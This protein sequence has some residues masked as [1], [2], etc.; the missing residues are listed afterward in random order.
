MSFALNLANIED[1]VQKPQEYGRFMQHC[2]LLF[3]VRRLS[4]FS[5]AIEKTKASG[6]AVDVGSGNGILSL[7]A[8]KHGYEHVFMIEPSDKI[9]QYAT[10]LLEKNGMAGRFTIIDQP[11][12]YVNLSRLPKQLGLVVS[13]T[14]SSLIFGFGSWD[15]FPTLVSRV[16]SKESII[17]TR[18]KLNFILVE[19]DSIP[20][21][22]LPPANGFDF[23]RSKSIEVDL[24]DYT[25]FSS[26]N[27][28]A[29]NFEK[30]LQNYIEESK[31]QIATMQGFDFTKSNPYPAKVASTVAIPSKAAYKGIIGWFSV[32]LSHDG[33]TILSSVDPTLF[34]WKPF[35]IPL[36]RP[37][38]GSE[39][40]EIS[41]ELMLKRVDAP[42]TYA[43]QFA[44]HISGKELTNI[45]YW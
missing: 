11:L 4:L 5:E 12:E 33:K 29:V 40:S 2:Y 45:L 42:Y 10:H 15:A 8:L 1:T 35:Y 19:D 27:M 36:K 23:L 34:A 39:F 18:G 32:E 24:L 25:F 9:A 6:V 44:D 14:I 17:P 38:K 37:I 3:D 20:R 43:F 21:T 28:Y 22:G 30:A 41:L 7:M 16:S 26:G 13:E 31:P